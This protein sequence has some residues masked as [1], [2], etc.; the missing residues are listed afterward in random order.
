M[1]ILSES[2][3]Y[4][5]VEMTIILVSIL[6]I[7]FMIIGGCD[8]EGGREEQRTPFPTGPPPGCEDIDIDPECPAV[9]LTELCDFWGGYSCDFTEIK[10]DITEPETI[11]LGIQLTACTS[12]DCFTL[13]CEE[14]FFPSTEI[15]I[16]IL[17]IME[18]ETVLDII[19]VAFSGTADIDGDE[20]DYVCNPPPI[21]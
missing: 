18:L 5:L 14:D 15:L 7:G 17:D 8:G 11:S 20:F 21:P 16:I 19:P 4:R 3:S 10:P 12:L 2:S 1:K 13:E 9:S 6:V